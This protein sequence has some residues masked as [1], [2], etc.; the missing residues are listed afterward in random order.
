MYN[1]ILLIYASVFA[2]FTMT[3]QNQC[4]AREESAWAVEYS[5]TEDVTHQWYLLGCAGVVLLTMSALLY[6]I[7]RT[8]EMFALMRPYVIIN[9]LITFTWFITI[10]YF[11]FKD[12]GRACAGDFILAAKTAKPAN[13]GTVYLV[14]QGEWMKIYVGS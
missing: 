3:E 8:P 4:Y 14:E 12:T 13:F 7:Q 10:Q 9:N 2:Y 6:H 1:I 5:N 11:R